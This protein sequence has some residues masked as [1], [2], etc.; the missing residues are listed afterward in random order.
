MVGIM[1]MV[2]PGARPGVLVMRLGVEEVPKAK[3]KHSIYP[4]DTKEEEGCYQSCSVYD[5]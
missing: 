2:I 5:A 1:I 3:A 4:R